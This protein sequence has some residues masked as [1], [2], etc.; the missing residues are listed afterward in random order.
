[1][2]MDSLT[3]A[4]REFV[5]EHERLH[6]ELS[7]GRKDD[8]GKLPLYLLPHDALEEV[9]KV[10]NHGQIKYTA[11]NWEKGMAWHRPY[12]ACLRHLWAWWR[13]EPNDPETGLSH[14]AHAT[15]CVLFLLS[16][17]LRGDGTDDRPTTEMPVTQSK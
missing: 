8:D 4:E 3:P 2:R 16:Y 5:A 14:L 11:R 15:C 10:L 7:E 9:A 13:G 6:A 1:M 12:S 17:T